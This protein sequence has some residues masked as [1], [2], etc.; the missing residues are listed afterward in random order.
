M[1]KELTL[2]YNKINREYGI[3]ETSLNWFDKNTYLFEENEN[4]LLGIKKFLTEK[5]YIDRK[6]MIRYN[7]KEI[8]LKNLAEAIKKFNPKITIDTFV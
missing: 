1:M 7:K 5:N 8:K 2:L 4:L 3:N 6:I